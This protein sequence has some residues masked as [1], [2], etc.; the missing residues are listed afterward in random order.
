[1]PEHFISSTDRSLESVL[2]VFNGLISLPETTENIGSIVPALLEVMKNA[3]TA[4][5]RQMAINCLIS[6]SKEIPYQSLHIHR[7]AIIKAVTAACDDRKRAV[8]LTAV[9]CRERFL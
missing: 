2:K 8:R 7:Q 1:M 9:S 5:A 4:A 6:I 3:R